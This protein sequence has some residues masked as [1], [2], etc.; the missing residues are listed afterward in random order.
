MQS[1]TLIDRSRY[2]IKGKLILFSCDA[3]MYIYLCMCMYGSMYVCFMHVQTITY[4]NGISIINKLLWF[5][6]KKGN[7]G[8]NVLKENVIQC[9]E[10]LEYKNQFL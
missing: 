9:Y 10:I 5:N 2:I 8:E 6:I 4:F 1:S 7:L 3:Y